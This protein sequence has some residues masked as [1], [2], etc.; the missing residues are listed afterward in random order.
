MALFGSL[1]LAATALAE[2]MR[3]VGEVLKRPGIVNAGELAAL[4]AASEAPGYLVLED[5]EL[6]AEVV[7]GSLVRLAAG[8]GAPVVA[9]GHSLDQGLWIVA[10]PA[11]LLI[12]NL[13][14]EFVESAL[15]ETGE[16]VSMWA[17]DFNARSPLTVPPD[18]NACTVTCGPGYYACCRYGGSKPACRCERNGS[19]NVCESGGEGATTCTIVQTRLQ[20][21]D[22]VEQ[23]AI[24]EWP[25][26]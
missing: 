23:D 24:D 13:D 7:T 6:V 12:T 19:N 10:E 20:T 16:I 25:A 15:L 1:L 2:P 17:T 26:P 14:G 5:R 22:D 8:H 9:D 11:S 3:S 21:P 18:G 4:A